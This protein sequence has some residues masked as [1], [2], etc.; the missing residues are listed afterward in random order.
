VAVS[1]AMPVCVLAEILV[2]GKD[3][4]LPRLRGQEAKTA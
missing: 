3:Y 1:L 2:Y 4:W